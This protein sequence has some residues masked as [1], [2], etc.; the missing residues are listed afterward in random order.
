[1][2]REMK[3]ALV[4]LFGVFISA[5]SQVILKKAAGREYASRLREYLNAPVITAYAV[6]F[7]STL[8]CVYAYRGIP[9]SLG[10]VLESTGYLYVTA[11]GALLFGERVTG[12][13][14]LALLLILGGIAV[15]AFAG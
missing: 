14:A 8:L 5:V 11:F 1:M 7:V 9:A 3:Y 10:A 4:L 15:Y 13:K 2:S 12:R 6:F